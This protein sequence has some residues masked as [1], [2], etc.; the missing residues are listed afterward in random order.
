MI[1][2]TVL[3][4]I[5]QLA[6]CFTLM[7]SSLP[8]QR[9]TTYI[10]DNMID[11]SHGS[12]ISRGSSV[13]PKSFYSC[14]EDLASCTS[15]DT[16]ESSPQEQDSVCQEDI[17]ISLNDRWYLNGKETSQSTMGGAKRSVRFSCSS[18]ASSHRSQPRLEFRL[19]PCFGAALHCLFP[20][21]ERGHT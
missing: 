15:S 8:M 2:T 17:V 21:P 5:T 10:V 9:R 19:M 14:K 18:T 12:P 20:R 11:S 1:C 4:S 3:I 16:L 7:S 13:A 6:P